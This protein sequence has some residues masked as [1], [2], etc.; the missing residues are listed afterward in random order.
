MSLKVIS[1]I[2]TINQSG[3]WR[4]EPIKIYFD[5][6]ID[7]TTIRWDTLNLNDSYSFS[8]VVGNLEP[9]WASGINLSG[10]TS[11]LMF[12]P[13]TVLLPLTEYSV[14]V[15]AK[16]NSVI[17]KDK[18]EIDST[19]TF[20]FVTGTGYYDALGH[21]GVPS[22][23]TEDIDIELSGILDSEEDAFT[24]FAVYSTTPKN[25]EPNLALT[26]SEIKVIFNGNISTP[27][28]TLSGYISIE[29]TDVI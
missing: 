5:R 14:Y 2:P 8:T 21:A 3:V 12:T 20:S 29:R 1:H 16:P 4:N 24:T 15:F 9:I 10:V 28:E 27:V 22:G 7:P 18:S 19:Y 11:G 25:Q 6:P 23:V 26:L 17:A 13:S